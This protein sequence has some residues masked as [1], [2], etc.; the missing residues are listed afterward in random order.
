VRVLVVDDHDASRQALGDVVLATG[1]FALVGSSS[2]GDEAL[3]MLPKLSPDLVLLDVQMPGLDGPATAHVITENRPEVA[4]VLV[5]AGELPTL[6]P[7]V[8]AVGVPKREISPR[9]LV[10]AWMEARDVRDVRARAAEARHLAQARVGEAA[11][12]HA[13]ARHQIRRSQ[14]WL[15]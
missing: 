13:Q 10:E 7:S 12:L 1:G 15:R 5:S 14:R 11:A 2:S 9:R 3:R 4:I 8:G 6:A